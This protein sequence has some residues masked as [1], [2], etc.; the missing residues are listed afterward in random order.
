MFFKHITSSDGSGIRPVS[1]ST[2]GGNG[3]NEYHLRNSR[4]WKNT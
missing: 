1:T 3:A 2:N 4:I